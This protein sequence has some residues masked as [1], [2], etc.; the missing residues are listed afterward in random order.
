MVL[1]LLC[2]ASFSDQ[3]LGISIGRLVT[4]IQNIQLLQA[5]TVPCPGPFR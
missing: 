2:V 1:R 3:A 5:S 4:Y